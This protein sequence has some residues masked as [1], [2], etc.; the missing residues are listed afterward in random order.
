V[1]IA[2][3]LSLYPLLFLASFGWFL[4]HLAPTCY[5]GDCAELLTAV[6]THGVPH[7]TGFPLYL[8]LTT[9]FSSFGKNAFWIN[10]LSAASSA[11]SL[12]LFLKLVEIFAVPKN[13]KTS[14]WLPIGWSFIF[15]SSSTFL[16]HSSVARIYPLNLTAILAVLA[17]ASYFPP[18]K[19][20]AVLGLGFLL[21]L[22]AGTHLL[23]VVTLPFLIIR[24]WEIRGTWA[25]NIPYF[26]TGFLT[27]LSLYLWIPLLAHQ[28]PAL[29][30]G[31]PEQVHSFL[32]Y[33]TQKS[34]ET[35]M[36]SRGLS[37][38]LLFLAYFFKWLAAQWPFYLW[39]LAVGGIAGLYQT[40]R[41]IFWALLSL[42]Y[43]NFLVIYA[44]GNEKDL[45]IGYRYFL[46][47]YFG[48]SVGMALG[49]KQLYERHTQ[50]TVKIAATFLLAVGFLMF[51]APW[52]GLGRSTASY[53][54]VLNLL[55]PLPRGSSM[56]I[57]GDNQ[58]FPV[59]YAVLADHLRPD[60]DF[61]ETSG[62]FFPRT[63]AEL[64]LRPDHSFKNFFQD[65]FKQSGGQI[66]LCSEK[67]NFPGDVVEPFGLCY[68]LATPQARKRLVDPPDP[69]KIFRLR[70]LSSNAKDP[71]IEA[72]EI[73]AEYP[74]FE[75]AHAIWR[76]DVKNGETNLNTA[77]ALGSDSIHTLNNIS[78]LYSK[79]H[80]F[81]KAR[82]C[83][84]KVRVLQPHLAV[85][86]LNLAILDGK[87]GHPQQAFSEIV[88]S[89]ELDPQNQE[90]LDY[91]EWLKNDLMN[92][93]KKTL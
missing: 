1:K 51:Q 64:D 48:L 10:A 69:E 65:K 16:L 3:P 47:F 89:L 61:I 88:Q 67:Y 76:G 70:N 43:A 30:W 90:A 82:I 18:Q 37:G 40:Q 71:D 81:K 92:P 54:Y 72:E 15:L 52:E 28:H 56:L 23:F 79:I 26:M 74:L 14:P 59:A 34:Y 66:Y 77:Q 38:S 58:V 29:N 68:R 27:G 11:G 93:S 78:A 60:I 36:D 25:K 35:K 33:L 55:K 84:E 80:D 20:P 86:Y 50:R 12:V 17:W 7:P 42:L 49:L 4:I 73:V 24:F 8:L 31:D 32:N 2:L 39:I 9:C 19:K 46:P 13:E 53:D 21:G 6:L 62:V 85:V 41:T 22:A 75:A 57:Q 45:Y 5:F 63:K 83:L 87:S 44:Y 91:Y